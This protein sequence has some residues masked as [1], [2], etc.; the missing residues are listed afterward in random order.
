MSERGRLMTNG[1][2][3]YPKKGRQPPTPPEG[4]MADETDPWVLHKIYKPCKFRAFT[5]TPTPCGIKR[6]TYFCELDKFVTTWRQCD[7]CTRAVIGESKQLNTTDE[8]NK[9]IRNDDGSFL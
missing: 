6:Y 9:T 1:D 4:Y 8:S 5:N 3:I 7:T 2:L